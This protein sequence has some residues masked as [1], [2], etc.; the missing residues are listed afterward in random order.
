MSLRSLVEN[1]FVACSRS[2]AS[3]ITSHF[4]E[5]AVV[6]DTNHKPVRGATP[7]GEFYASVREQ[8]G[9]AI[10]EVNT[11]VGDNE[12]AAIEWSMHGQKDGQQFSVRGSEHYEFRD[13]LIGEIRQYWTFNRDNPSVGLR[14]FPYQAQDQFAAFI[15]DEQTN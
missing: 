5:D 2:D 4:C 14:G 10:W 6:Y 11:Y 12:V 15:S 1:Y 8:W 7:I 3:A 9:G 13:G